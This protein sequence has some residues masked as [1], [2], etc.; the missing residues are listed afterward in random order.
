MGEPS[1]PVPSYACLRGARCPHDHIIQRRSPWRPLASVFR[2]PPPLRCIPVGVVGRAEPLCGVPSTGT[3]AANTRPPAL[4][5]SREC[6]RPSSSAAHP[7]P[8][9]PACVDLCTHMRVHRGT[10]P[11]HPFPPQRFS[12]RVS[13]T[14][15]A[16]AKA[17]SARACANGRC[18]GAP[19]SARGGQRRRRT[20]NQSG[21]RSVATAIAHPLLL[22]LLQRRRR[23]SFDF[24]AEPYFYVAL[25]WGGGRGA[26]R[27]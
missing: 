24:P 2:C 27:R 8:R 26:G 14:S 12:A 19:L 20:H 15:R 11:R 9:R 7:P 4:G 10:C 13:P 25:L 22:L 16:S 1:G 23:Q 6:G 21:R 18:V 17:G 5:D 3:N